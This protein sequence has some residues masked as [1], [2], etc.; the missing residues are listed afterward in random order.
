MVRSRLSWKHKDNG[1]HRFVAVALD[2]NHQLVDNLSLPTIS[3]DLSP[4]HQTCRA[5]YTASHFRPVWRS[6]LRRTCHTR[7]LFAPASPIDAMSAQYLESA[8]LSPWCFSVPM[9][10]NTFSHTRTR[11]FDPYGG[12]LVDE[13]EDGCLEIILL[14][15]GRFLLTERG[16]R[17]GI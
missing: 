5:L 1:D 2:P 16:C 9:N 13:D 7:R 14:Y 10:S 3:T 4:F 12:L 6:A 17:C 15:G 8:A 11:V